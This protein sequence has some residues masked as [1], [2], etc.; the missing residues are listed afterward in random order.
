LAAELARTRENESYLASHQLPAPVEPTNDL[1][2]VLRGVG[3]VVLAVPTQGLR[4]VLML[5]DARSWPEVPLV[6]ACK[7]IEVRSLE[8]PSGIV[9]A[10][11]GRDAERRSV[12]LSGPSFAEE[13]ASGQPTAVVAACDEDEHAIVVQRRVSDANLRAYSSEDRLGVQLAGALKNVVA[14]AAGVSD[15]LG[16]G[17]NARAALITRS[18]AEIARLGVALGARHA[19][20]SGLAGVG[21]LVLTCTGALSRNRHVGLE[22]GRGRALDEILAATRMVAEG[23]ATARAAWRLANQHRVEMPI[24]EQVHQILNEGKAP[25]RALDDLLSRP[26]RSETESESR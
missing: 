8:L 24:V 16:F 9:R 20:F 14:I 26:L 21:D 11:L 5:A 17:N 23:V 13:L 7:G 15:G 6:L 25:E 19:T 1:E 22:L 12:A 2:A 3:V 4:E 10:V 18:L